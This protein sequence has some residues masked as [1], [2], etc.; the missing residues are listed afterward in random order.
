[1]PFLAA[2]RSTVGSLRA[3]RRRLDEVQERVDAAS[4]GVDEWNVLYRLRLEVEHR[5]EGELGERAS[6]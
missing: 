6:A 2:R 4:L 3:L 1:M 5:A